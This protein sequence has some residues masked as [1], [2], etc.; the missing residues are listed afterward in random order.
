M[1]NKR[2]ATLS[3]D[4]R[5]MAALY[6]HVVH[7]IRTR[8]L[9]SDV[10]EVNLTGTRVKSFSDL[11]ALKRIVRQFHDPICVRLNQIGLREVGWLVQLLCTWTKNRKLDLSGN[12]ISLEDMKKLVRA[13]E[14]RKKGYWL[15]IGSN[16]DL[17]PLLTTPTSCHPHSWR[18][19]LCK[20]KMTVHVIERLRP[21]SKTEILDWEAVH[22]HR[23]PLTPP[24]YL[25]GYVDT[26]LKLAGAMRLLK[27]LE[28]ADE[29]AAIK[30]GRAF[31]YDGLTYHV[32]TDGDNCILTNLGDV[33][34]EGARTIAGAR[35]QLECLSLPLRA[36]GPR[37]IA[38]AAPF[39]P[40]PSMDPNGYL[41]TNG[42]EL[43]LVRF[44][45]FARA[46]DGSGWIA[47]AAKGDRDW[48]WF[49]LECVLL[50]CYSIDR[51]RGTA[52]VGGTLCSHEVFKHSP[53]RPKRKRCGCANCVRPCLVEQEEAR[54]KVK[55]Q[56]GQC[57]HVQRR[58]YPEGPRDNGEYCIVCVACGKELWVTRDL[59]GTARE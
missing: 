36:K 24:P 28:R 37:F 17:K 13:L 7:L 47:A 44:D 15:A 51:R 48:R 42:G 11:Q 9:D 1:E 39:A 25:K 33:D 38:A 2:V 35:V 6:K 59:R 52:L 29:E 19:C 55:E 41:R 8:R 5:G 31:K 22:I 10:Y 50:P 56:Q 27:R 21:F 16:D 4:Q 20:D 57:E 18:G 49:P 53:K 45:M 32:M 58:V 40:A 12:D 46:S 3:S 30:E 54:A 43:L 26:S 23:T 34:S 14:S